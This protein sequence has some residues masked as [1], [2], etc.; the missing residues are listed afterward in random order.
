MGFAISGVNLLHE[1]SEHPWVNAALETFTPPR[2]FAPAAPYY[3]LFLGGFDNSAVKPATNKS[4]IPGM[5]GC[6]RGFKIG[7]EQVF[8]HNMANNNGIY[9]ATILQIRLYITFDF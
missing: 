8:I 3:Q 1:Y 6:L 7:E 5:L 4:Q 2:P 9:L